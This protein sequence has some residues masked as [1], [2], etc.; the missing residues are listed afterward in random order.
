MIKNKLKIA[1]VL[2]AVLSSNCAW[3]EEKKHY[4]NSVSVQVGFNGT[5]Q[6]SKYDLQLLPPDLSYSHELFSDNFI[7]STSSF[8]D[9]IGVKVQ[10]TEFTYRIGQRMDLGLEVGKYTPYLCLGLGVIRNDHH[11]QTSPVYGSGLSF[12]LSQRIMWI[13]ELNFQNVVYHKNHYTIA[14]LSTGI[15]YNF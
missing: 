9:N 11:Y 15:V 10:D 7:L 3:T 2:W 6:D 13:N 12:A 14:N 8:Y 4:Y 5:L 1:L